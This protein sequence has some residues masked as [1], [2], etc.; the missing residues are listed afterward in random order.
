MPVGVGVCCTFRFMCTW[1]SSGT[2]RHNQSYL[3]CLPFRFF[4]CC[5]HVRYIP[6][7]V[8]Y[9]MCVTRWYVVWRCVVVSPKH[10]SSLAV[11]CKHLRPTDVNR[12]SLPPLSSSSWE[13]IVRLY[14]H[15]DPL[16]SLPPTSHDHLS[17]DLLPFWRAGLFFILSHT[18]L[19][20]NSVHTICG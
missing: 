9:G 15:H 14:H 10:L 19:A 3:P 17:C 2:R 4:S 1:E 5:V 6:V 11:M 16:S 13:S 18:Y 7:C 20:Q 12:V 8:F